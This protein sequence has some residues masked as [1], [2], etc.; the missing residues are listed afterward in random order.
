MRNKEG[1]FKKKMT[2]I[3]MSGISFF[4]AQGIKNE[5]VC[6]KNTFQHMQVNPLYSQMSDNQEYYKAFCAPAYTQESEKE[7]VQED[8]FLNETK[9]LVSEQKVSLQEKAREEKYAAYLSVD[10]LLQ[11]YTEQG[12]TSLNEEEVRM[13][14][15]FF[16]TM[17]GAR[18]AI[19]MQEDVQESFENGKDPRQSKKYK[20]MELIQG[21][22][23]KSIP[24]ERKEEIQKEVNRFLQSQQS[25]LYSQIS[26]GKQRMIGSHFYMKGWKNERI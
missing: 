14:R 24:S 18:G 5:D 9:F 2:A 11:I 1:R 23:F 25:A 21:K 26:L 17:V 4:G 16:A 8:T 6:E 20:Q 7:S 12:R 22:I 19:S 13:V 10:G 3:F 15:G